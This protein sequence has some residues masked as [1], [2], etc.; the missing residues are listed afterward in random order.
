MHRGKQ[1][2]FSTQSRKERNEKYGVTTLRALREISKKFCEN[3]NSFGNN[4]ILTLNLQN[5][6]K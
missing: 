4:S 3:K 5:K 6:Y 1:I 2:L